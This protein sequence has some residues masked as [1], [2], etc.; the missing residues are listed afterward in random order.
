[1][2]RLPAPSVQ[3]DD[4]LCFALYAA[5]R[6]VTARYRPMLEELGLTYPQYLVMMLLW[7]EDDQTVGQLGA[8]LALDSGTLSP[9]LKRLTAAGLVTRQRRVDDERSVSV[10]LTPAGRELRDRALPVSEAMIEAIGFVQDDFDDLKKQLRI[11]VERVNRG[12]PV[13]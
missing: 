5:S 10:S 3:L 6:A 12:E 8:R 9:L 4:Q 11:V 7:E 1:M 13:C 2:S